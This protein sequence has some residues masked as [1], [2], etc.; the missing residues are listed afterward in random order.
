MRKHAEKHP[1]LW[2]NTILYYTIL[3]II[4]SYTILYY[5]RFNLIQRFVDRSNNTRASVLDLFGGTLSL[6]T[7]AI[8]LN[9]RCA[10]Y[11]KDSAVVKAAKERLQ[12]HVRRLTNKTKRQLGDQSF[13]WGEKHLKDE[14]QLEST[15]AKRGSAK[16]TR[17]K[18]QGSHDVCI[19]IIYN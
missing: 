9:V 1:M 5:T 8:Y 16:K 10:F 15:K 7:A 6:G 2:F 14:L 13:P 17:K 4:I 12:N 11:E 3:Y 19:C 18:G